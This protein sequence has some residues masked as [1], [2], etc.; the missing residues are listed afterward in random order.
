MFTDWNG[1]TFDEHVTIEDLS[2]D[3]FCTNATTTFNYN[4]T[5]LAV[6]SLTFDPLWMGTNSFINNTGNLTLFVQN[7]SSN[8][9]GDVDIAVVT[10]KI[11]NQDV[12]KGIP[13]FFDSSV[14]TLTNT[15][16]YGLGGQIPVDPQ[17]AIPD[18]QVYRYLTLILPYLS[19]DGGYS[20]GPGILVGTL[21]NVTVSI[22]DVNGLIQKMIA[23]RY[24]LQYDNNTLQ[25]V[26][27]TEGPLFRYFASLEP[28]SL[29]TLFQSNIQNDPT[30]GWNVNVSQALY[31]NS[32]GMYNDPLLNGSGVIAIITFKVLTQ[33]LGNITTPLT[34]ADE[35]ATGLDSMSVQHQVAEPLDTPVDGSVTISALEDDV[36]IINIA[37]S[38]TVFSNCTLGNIT[39]TAANLGY[40]SE[41]FNVT[42]YVNS[43]AISTFVNVT[44]NGGE[45]ATLTTL[46]NTTGFAIGNYTLNA[47]AWPVPNETNTDNNNFTGGRIIVSIVGDI[48][49]PSGWPDGKVD[50]R[51]VNYVAKRY[52]TTSS[53]S[54]WDPDADVTGSTLGVPD[55]KVDIR[56]VHYVAIYYGATPSSSN[57]NPNA[58]INN[59]GKIDIRDVHIVAKNYG[60]HYP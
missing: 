9:S 53:S 27:A 29:G 48:T 16:L 19:V 10:F 44:L 37:S 55:G 33:P 12:T 3:W 28:G 51:D 52:G 41:T 8:P 14:R 20:L 60:Q 58:D 15:T 13:G 46:W 21:F 57:W 1:T 11:V 39:V 40:S 43:D 59:D 22:N 35:G 7:P 42:A 2:A 6:T 25:A 17:P 4:G 18:I 24:R 31:P 34:I 26:N 56:D 45:F 23:V 38:K 30:F 47:Y 32:T 50:I 5:L 49:G 36:A 54:N